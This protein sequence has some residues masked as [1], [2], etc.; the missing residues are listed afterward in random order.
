MLRRRT[1][2]CAAS[3]APESEYRI[4]SGSPW[5]AR[6]ASASASTSGRI[7]S[8]SVSIGKRISTG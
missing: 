4:T 2:D 5:T 1:P 7:D 3:Q 6:I 8:R